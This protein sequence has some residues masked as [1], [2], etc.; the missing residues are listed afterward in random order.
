LTARC[1][2]LIG[3]VLLTLGAVTAIAAPDHPKRVL[4]LHSFEPDFADEFARPL[5]EELDRQLQ[6]Q[7]EL[8]E[9]WLVSERFESRGGDDAALAQYLTA[10]FA[11]HPLDLI[12]TLGGPAANFVQRHRAT[13]FPST[14]VVLTG[15]EERRVAV[16]GLTG[17][18]TTV[19]FS[20]DDDITIRTILRILPET[21]TLAVVIGNSPIEKYWM[22]QIRNAAEPFRGRLN[23]IFLN[24]LT[25]YDEVL[26]RVATLPPRSA[27]Y[28]QLF[29]E[30]MPGVPLNEYVALDKL[31]AAAN[32]PIFGILDLYVGKGTVGGP[33]LSTRE[34]AR[35]GA[36]VVARI[37]RGG[38]ASDSKVPPLHL[39]NPLYDWREL[40]RWNIKESALPPGSEILYRA[41]TAWERYRWQIVSAA[42]LILLQAALI[43]SLLYERRRRKK[44]EI[45]AHDRVTQL[46]LM[47][48][49][50][51][52]GEL[53]A[54]IAHEL[55]QPVG[56]ILRDSDVAEMILNE[57]SPDLNELKD[58]V[59]T[60]K[61]ANQRSEDV[62]NRLHGL[63]SKAPLEVQEINLNQVVSEVFE[64]LTPQAS[65]RGVSLIL[66]LATPAQR[67]VGDGVQLQ[68]VIL[69]LVMNALEAITGANSAERRVTG[70]TVFVGVTAAE[71][72]IADSGPGIPADKLQHIFDPFFTTKEGGMG[73]GLAIVRT[74]VDAHGGRI[75]AENQLGG[76][77][78]FRFSLPLAEYSQVAPRSSADTGNLLPSGPVTDSQ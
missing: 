24:D 67:V 21:T 19:A 73:M 55:R 11:D 29:Y 43:L 77:A 65:V 20:R 68:Q 33:T 58:I 60:I 51:V 66:D 61:R 2:G 30:G 17:N 15:V 5:R 62:I 35:R 25:T 45:E 34:F 27:I 13:L 1:A 78:V 28:F 59:G 4:L 75:S 39:G 44:A 16:F 50:A 26:K 74:I 31:H 64:L 48:R 14:P 7:I 57:P 41:P 76:G 32:A 46:A 52:A 40:K 72:S 49:R 36:S 10:S 18:E 53:S 8:Y 47:N 6:G 69:N 38:Q 71:V 9:N 63:L 42:T 70:R 23:L 56:L 3:I 12:I 22:G 54:A 37:L